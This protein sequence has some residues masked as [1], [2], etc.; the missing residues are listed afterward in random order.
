MTN[1]IKRRKIIL[2]LIL[3]TF[4]GGFLRFYQFS[5]LLRFN[6]DQARDASVIDQMMDKNEFPLLG[7]KAGGTTFKLGPAFYYL[8]YIS[9]FLFGHN[10]AGMAF[11]IPLLATLSIPLFFL[12]LRYYFSPPLSLFLSFLYATSFYAIKYSRFAWNPNVI[13][14]FILL[15][16]IAIL[17]IAG[18]RE[19]KDFVWPVILGIALGIGIQLHT[20]LLF[21]MPALVATAFIF[22]YFKKQN[23]ILAKLLYVFTIAIVLNLPFLISDI[24]NNG[25]NIN[26][27]FKGAEKKTEADGTIVKNILAEGQFFVQGNFYVLSSYEPQKNWLKVKKLVSSGA[28]KEIIAAFSGSLFFLFGLIRLILSFQKEKEEKRKKFLGLVLLS[29]AFSFVL[30]LPLASELNLRF[31]I[32]LVFLP[33]IF[34]GLLINFFSRFLDKKTVYLAM[35]LVALVSAFFNLKTYKNVYDLE[36]Y[37]GK[38][39]IYGGISLKEARDISQFIHD[40]SQKKNEK[41][42]KKL[43]LYPFEFSRS[44]NYL[45][46]RAGVNISVLSGEKLDKNSILFMVIKS[47]NAKDAETE[48]ECCYLTLASKN[49]G[50][51]TV[52]ALEGKN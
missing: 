19:R 28:S 41:T 4:I 51:F 9:A 17:K 36:N 33:F 42:G 46:K 13:P 14:F 24:K 12:F 20:I 40:F 30:F 32:V 6:A 50:R 16:L 31:F 44:V 2:L 48:N 15:F 45:N 35:A 18:K 25:N 47:K 49:L 23:K 21:L 3:I 39:D 37:N 27:F 52:L 43:Y 34:L 22:L 10:P 7:P 1:F 8:E 38:S 29:F 11:F 5:D 26:S